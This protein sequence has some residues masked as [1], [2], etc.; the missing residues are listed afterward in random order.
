MIKS[1]YD[2]KKMD[3]PSNPELAEQFTSQLGISEFIANILINRGIDNLDDAKHFLT[4][5]ITDLND[6]FL[7]PDMQKTVERIQTAIASGEQITVYGDYDADGITSTTIMFE[8]IEDLGGN[9]DIYVPNRFSDGYGPNVKAFKNIINDGTT[10]II[11]VDN[12]VAG[13]KAIEEANKLGCDVIVTDHHDLP[14][15]L[16][17]A[18]AIV[19]PR[20]KTSDGNLYPFGMLSGAGVAFKVAT[21]LLDEVP[22]DLLDIA[23]IGTVAD[24]VSLTGENRVIV[25]FGIQAIQN[26]QRPGLLAL[27]KQAKVNL[28]T[29]NEQDIGFALAPRLNSLG[30][31]GDAKVGVDLLHTFDEEE[32]QEI[33]KFADKQNDERKE[34]VDNFFAESLK[35]IAADDKSKDAPVTVVVGKEW[36]QG[37][38]GIVASRL[39]DQFQRPAIVLTTLAD[40]DE[41]KGSGRSIPSFDLFNA[42]D[43]IRDKMVGF[44][45][46]HSAVGLTMPADQL[47]TLKSQLAKSAQEQGLDLTTKSTKMITSDINIDDVNYDFYEDLRKLAPFG[48]DNPEPVFEF[49][50]SEIA[51]VKR[52]GQDSSHLKFSIKGRKNQIG[53]IA[54]K[55]GYCAD[56]L[57]DKSSTTKIIGVIG[58]NT[59]RNQTNLQI[60]VEDMRQVEQPVIDMRTNRLHTKMFNNS[61]TYVFFHQSIKQQLASVIPEDGHAY[62]FTDLVERQVH[63]DTV[64]IVDCPD[65]IEDLKAVLKNTTPNKTIFYLYKKQL[66][67]K[68]GMPERQSYAK[69]FKFVSNHQDFDIVNQLSQAA[70]GLKIDQR[71]LAFMIKVFL[72]LG[73]VSRS[74]NVIRLN[75]APESKQLQ[76]APSYQLREKQIDA[77]QHLLLANTS[78]LVSFVSNYFETDERKK[79]NGN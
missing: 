13:N 61:G 52:I 73:F 15:V 33:A 53:V 30:R 43:P 38:L 3:V 49:K 27:L 26:T 65:D 21:A 58:T 66:V 46:H 31:M 42:I 14:D 44:G 63:L 12:G 71:S 16:P 41:I 79:L 50:F 7:L 78:E 24:V 47:D 35:I 48:E 19:H 2:W 20:V 6:P 1:K 37:V 55:L 23:S 70:D 67:S 51:D 64:F 10:L 36:H 56:D 8:A 22:Y 29:F 59:W 77:E 5:D 60:M 57:V 40:S 39:V 72:E 18:Y 45:G 69:L 68:I 62:L 25:S 9:V 74:G 75:P 54:F 28:G 34:Y 32:A 76:T 11:T 17:N 4:P